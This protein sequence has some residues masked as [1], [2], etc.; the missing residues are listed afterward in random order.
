[1]QSCDVSEKTSPAPEVQLTGSADALRWIARQE[2]EAREEVEHWSTAL[3]EAQ[4]DAFDNPVA[5]GGA[6]DG[7]DYREQVKIARANLDDAESRA[8]KWQKMLKD[9]DK[10][11][12]EGKRDTTEKVN[13]D[14]LERWLRM[15]AVS[16][17]SGGEDTIQKYAQNCLDCRTREE[18][19]EL[20][21]E[22]LR[23]AFRNAMDSSIRAGHFEPWFLK[24]MEAFI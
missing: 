22:R 13:R 16:L 6:T 5:D 8:I 4:Q 11:V 20:I 12:P 3:K 9:F 2:K 17:R 24:A 21:S 15:L 18:V 14:D 7:M 19:Y 23:E 10:I 1:M